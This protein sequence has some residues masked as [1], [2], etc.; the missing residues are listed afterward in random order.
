[1]AADHTNEPP[2]HQ[3][4][5]KIKSQTAKLTKSSAEGGFRHFDLCSLIF[6]LCVLLTTPDAPEEISP[7]RGRL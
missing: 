1:M 2:N 7:K 5:A 6:D 4:S 3:N